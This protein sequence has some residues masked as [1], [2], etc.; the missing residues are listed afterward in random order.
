MTRSRLKTSPLPVASCVVTLNAD[1]VVGVEFRE[2]ADP[3]LQRNEAFVTDVRFP[4]FLK[5]DDPAYEVPLDGG[6]TAIVRRNASGPSQQRDVN[7]ILL[8]SLVT[9]S[10][11]VLTSPERYRSGPA[12]AVPGSEGKIKYDFYTMH[13]INM[14][15]LMSITLVM[16]MNL[17]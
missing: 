8:D 10:L 6:E 12:S 13:D 16:H 3:V 15:A 7:N 4:H 1:Y 11:L 17:F 5:N 14:I 9:E 2:S